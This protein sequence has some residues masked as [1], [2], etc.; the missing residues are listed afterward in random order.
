MFICPHCE[1]RLTRG[2]Q[3]KASYWA[4][5]GCG[6]RAVNFVNLRRLV[7]REAGMG[8]WRA[9]REM[10]NSDGP[11]CPACHRAMSKE[12]FAAGDRQ[13]AL[14]A[15]VP[16]QF[17][18]F[19]GKDFGA[20]PEARTDKTGEEKLPL[21]AQLLIAK[22]E[23]EAIDDHMPFETA[24]EPPSEAWKS[25]P[26]FLGLPVEYDART[27]EKPPV[28][29]YGLA[30]AMV[31]LGALGF[32]YFEETVQA[33]GMI[34]R[35]W[36]RYGGLTLLTNFFLQ[37]GWLQLAVNVYFL[38]VFGD[39]VEDLLGRLRYLIL[40]LL[41]TAV[42][43]LLHAF[44][45]S[46]SM[47]PVIGAHSGISA[48]LWFYGLQFP[49][50]KVGFLFRYF[51]FLRWLRVPAWLYVIFWMGIQFVSTINQPDGAIQVTILGLFGGAAVGCSLWIY[52]LLQRTRQIEA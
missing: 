31:V 43:G 52:Y 26:G 7:E 47:I 39:D 41:A 17:A 33:L 34:P 28:V 32:V 42:G 44:F 20:L 24:P 27:I 8:M 22:Y 37:P 13:V 18:W 48:I 49:R 12:R 45:D 11:K 30:G 38:M 15:C 19:D 10:K 9:I 35:E 25:I 36:Q 4:C 6:G 29:T 16:C 3:R 50:A 21:E 14:D 1:Q 51:A 40:I 2:N 5:A 46:G 23:I